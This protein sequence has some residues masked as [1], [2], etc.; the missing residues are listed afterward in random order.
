MSALSIVRNIWRENEGA[1]K[2]K[3]LIRGFMWQV[4]KR[5][6][7]SF[8]AALPNGAR[9][10]VRPLSTYS[11]LFYFRHHERKDMLFIERHASLAD[12][13]VD[14][15]ANVG[16]FSA[17]LF[18]RFHRFVLFEP[19]PSS[20]AA[21]RQTLRL[22]AVDARAENMGVGDCTETLHF[23]DEGGCSTTSRFVADPKADQ[24]TIQVPCDTLDNQLSGERGTFVVKID[25]EGFEERVFRGAGQLLAGKRIKLV[26][27]ERL[28]RTNIER[29][30]DYLAGL[31]YVVFYV[32][33][34]G[35][36]SQDPADVTRPLENLFA[37]P[38]EVLGTLK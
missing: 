36:T 5:L 15:G 3:Y 6:G 1:D 26:M 29:I 28:G 16:L 7:H 32:R 22:N 35:T 11:Q 20:Y 21:L 10:Q 33:E 19:A 14:V 30:Q 25:V 8:V 34:D 4:R 17:A 18:G 2:A 27:F 13:F 38:A 9:V 24:R 31:G 37:C 12:T 23:L